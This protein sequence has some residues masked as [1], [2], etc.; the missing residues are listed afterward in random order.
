M[1]ASA[2]GFRQRLG[3]GV[4]LRFR[5]SRLSACTSLLPLANRRPKPHQDYTFRIWN[6]FSP[7]PAIVHVEKLYLLPVL[8]RVGFIMGLTLVS[9]DSSHEARLEKCPLWFR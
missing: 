2:A 8:I 1:A 9:D 4:A 7:F 6:L 5:S 3:G